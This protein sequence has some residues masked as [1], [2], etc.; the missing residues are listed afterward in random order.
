MN[1]DVTAPF[2][3]PPGGGTFP[4]LVNGVP[5]VVG[6]YLVRLTTA[7][8]LRTL[9][10]HQVG[11]TIAPYPAGSAR[12]DV[13]WSYTSEGCE[14]FRHVFS[15]VLP[16]PVDGD[17]LGKQLIHQSRLDPSATWFSWRGKAR[18][19][20][21]FTLT[22]TNLYRPGADRGVDALWDRHNAVNQVAREELA[23]VHQA[24]NNVQRML[25]KPPT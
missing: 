24:V 21:T 19:G 13:V 6:P 17:H 23:K 2:Q 14:T 5:A 15:A 11:V 16:R 22:V 7:Q 8:Y 9:P 25:E 18:K 20:V 1:A 12:M 4:L 10:M 3:T